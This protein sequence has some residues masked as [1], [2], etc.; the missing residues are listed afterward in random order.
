[1]TKFCMSVDI[2]DIITCATFCDDR[3]RGLGVARGRIS[4]FP[5]D[6]RRRPYNT[7]ALPCECVI[8]MIDSI[9]H[10]RIDPMAVV[11]RTCSLSIQR[12]FPCDFHSTHTS[13]GGRIAVASQLHP[14]R[15]VHTMLYFKCDLLS[16][17][18]THSLR[19]VGLT[20]HQTVFIKPHLVYRRQASYSDFHKIALI[21]NMNGWRWDIELRKVFLRN[22]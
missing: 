13:R 2:H 11:M 3:L 4:R 14:L 19:L 9:S 1:M 21:W 18:Y 6:F 12:L 5:I 7:L 15:K 10:A 20:R 22:S 8:L 17:S 16:Q